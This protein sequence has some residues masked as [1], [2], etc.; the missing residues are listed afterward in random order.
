MAFNRPT[1]TDLITRIREDLRTRME[2]TSG[3]VRRS[4][5]VVMATVFGGAVHMLHGHLDWITRQAFADTAEMDALKR[6]ALPYGMSPTAPTFAT[7]STL[8]TGVNGSSIPSGTALRRSDGATYKTTAV[9]TI[10]A[11]VA[12]IPVTADV[13]ALDGNAVSGVILTFESPVTGVNAETTV[14]AAGLINGTDEETPDAFRL[15]YME[16]LREPPQGGADPDYVAWAK[17]V[18]GVTRAWTYANELGLGTVVVRFVRDLESP[19]IPDGGE[20]AVVQT[21]LDAERPVTAAVTAMAPVAAPVAFTIA[22]T[23][24]TAATRAAVTDELTDMLEREA[25][26]GDGAGRGTILLSEMQ[27]AIGTAEGVTDFTLTVPAANVVPTL[28]QLP[29]L[30]TITFV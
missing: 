5:V 26:P 12:T 21:A 15:R 14:T 4:V 17:S 24:N 2:I 27:V 30:G 19:I 18:A 1:L 23:P 7:G 16:R 9:A 20:V 13:A 28:G 8:A 11:G 22:L 29:T 10:A 3:V 25:A 6:M